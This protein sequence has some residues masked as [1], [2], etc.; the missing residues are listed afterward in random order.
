MPNGASTTFPRF[1]ALRNRPWSSC[2]G[3]QLSGRASH[4]CDPVTL[5]CISAKV[6]HIS[7]EVDYFMIVESTQQGG[8]V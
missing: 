7:P 6:A 2:D 8:G 1:R 4:L 5:P 3:A